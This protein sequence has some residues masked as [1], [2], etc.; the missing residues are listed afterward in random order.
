MTH[1]LLHLSVSFREALSSKPFDANVYDLSG[2]GNW[3]SCEEIAWK[4]PGEASGTWKA[5]SFSV[6]A[7]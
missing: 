6:L 5:A 1:K 2:L 4:L 3:K 7:A